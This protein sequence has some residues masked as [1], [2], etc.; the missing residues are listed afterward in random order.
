MKQIRFLF[1]GIIAILMIQCKGPQTLTVPV[2][3]STTIETSERIT[4]EPTWTDPESLLYQ[5]AFECDEAY[6]VILKQYNELNSGLEGAVEIKEV[7]IYREDKSKVN[8]LLVNIS[9]L[10]DSLEVQNRTITKL[11]KEKRVQ[12]VPYPV[13]GPEVRY[14]P[15]Y[16]R[17]T[18]WVLPVL[19]LLI[20]LLIYLRIKKKLFRSFL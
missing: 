1:I 5:F 9:V 19:L 16:H 3:D 12:Q 11:R 8:R 14:I 17:I 15:K 20:G 7:L 4:D 13:P 10:V 2:H 6:N 18:A